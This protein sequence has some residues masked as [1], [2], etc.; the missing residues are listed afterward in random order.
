MAAEKSK[1][2]SG[3]ISHGMA[4]Q[5]RKARFDYSILEQIEAGLV[6][7]GPEGKRDRKSVV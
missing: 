1:G 4:A 7:R 6:L 5:N 2:K 3:L